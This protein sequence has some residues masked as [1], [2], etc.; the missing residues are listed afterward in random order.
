MYSES[1]KPAQGLSTLSLSKLGIFTEIFTKTG[2]SGGAGKPSRLEFPVAVQ[3]AQIDPVF[4]S[5]TPTMM[6]YAGGALSLV[7]ALGLGMWF[8]MSQSGNSGAEPPREER[9]RESFAATRVPRFDADRA[10]GYLRD[11]CKLGPRLS[12]TAEMKQQQDLLKKH[13]EALGGKVEFQRFTARQKSQRQPVEMA[14]VIVS[15]YPDRQRRVILCSHYDRNKPFL[16]ANDGASGVALLMEL[17]HQMKN[18][19][20]E[21]GV[22]FVLFDGEEYVF[23][24]GNEFHEGDKYFFGSEHFAQQYRQGRQRNKYAAAVLLDMI[25][26]KNAS[27][28]IEQNS[29]LKAGPLVQELW[30]VAAMERCP[31][32]R[33]EMGPSVR[34]DHL[35]LNRA[36]I[37]AVDVIDFHYPHW[38]RLTDTPENCSGTTMGQVAQV[39]ISW[40]ERIR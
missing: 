27:F 29:W 4:V 26:G 8:L 5:R 10:M 33:N 14:N 35:A 15:W 34:D 19:Q 28:P 6:R 36:G 25:A 18:L 40:L 9:P 21:V 11:I 17:A 3:S 7:T 31:L 13:F 22:D 2:W 39:L 30:T 20:T 23:D 38:H 12:G 24:P 16:S 1:N 37:P 32:F